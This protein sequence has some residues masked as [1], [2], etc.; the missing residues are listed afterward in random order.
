MAKK[1]KQGAVIKTMSE[2]ENITTHG[3]YLFMREKPIH[4]GWIQSMTFRT[5][6]LFLKSNK[7]RKAIK[8]KEVTK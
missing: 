6:W 3:E 4:P 5:I 7:L 2:V 1:Y 8:I